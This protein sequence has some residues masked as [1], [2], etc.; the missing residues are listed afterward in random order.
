[1]L[2]AFVICIKIPD[3]INL[4]SEKVCFSSIVVGLCG[5]WAGVDA[6]HTDGFVWWK[7]LFT[8]G[9]WKVNKKCMEQKGE[10]SNIPSMV[11]SL[12]T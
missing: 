8:D 5:D 3:R 12:E 10:G 4:V 1:M 7:K 11:M 2:A 6:V 9:N